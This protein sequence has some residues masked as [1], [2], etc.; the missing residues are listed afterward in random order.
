MLI[1]S[2]EEIV[3]NKQKNKKIW[4]FLTKLN[5]ADIKSVDKSEI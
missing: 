1:I 2:I 5:E 4:N 3:F